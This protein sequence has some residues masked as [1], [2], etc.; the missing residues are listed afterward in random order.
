MYSRTQVAFR[1]PQQD[2]NG[3]QKAYTRVN[4]RG[5]LICLPLHLAS[6]QPDRQR[7]AAGKY[8]P[9]GKNARRGRTQINRP[10]YSRGVGFLCS[11][12]LLLR[13]A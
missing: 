11:A 1:R 7:K 8:R 6:K 9:V 4:T 10:A 2:S 5:R 3:R 13:C 12:A